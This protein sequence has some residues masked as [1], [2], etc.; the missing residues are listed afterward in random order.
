MSR[1]N[2]LPVLSAENPGVTLNHVRSLTSSVTTS[3]GVNWN[4]EFIARDI[5]QNFFDANR[6]QLDEV[7]VDVEGSK[8]TI[9][10]PADFELER[11]FYLGSEKGEG[12]I[13]QYGEG[14]KVAAV[15]LL[16]DHQIE[17]MVI[18]GDKVVYLRVET[19]KVSGT[20]LQPV[21][22][23]FFR[24]SKPAKGTRLILPG[25]SKNLIRALQ[26]GLTHFMY[27]ENPLLGAKLWSSWD[28]DFALYRATT[29]IGHIFYRS[30]KR[31]ETPDIPVVLVIDRKYEQIE[32]KIRHDRDRNAFGDE[33]MKSFYRHFAQKGVKDHADGQSAIVV[34]AA[35]C[36]TRGHALLNEVA[37]CSHSHW[38]RA[39][40]DSVFGDRFYAHSTA[41]DAAQSLEYARLEKIW[42]HEA[43]T[44]LP[45]YFGRFGV[46]NARH[47]CEELERK[48]SE[49]AR[50]RHHRAPTAAESSAIKLLAQIIRDLAP[51]T[52]ALFDRKTTN[53]SV[54][55]TEVVLGELKEKRSYYSQDVFLASSLFVADFAH[56]LAVFLHEHTHVFGQDG[57]RG[58][59]DALTELLE[60]LVRHRRDLDAFEAR[61]NE[62]QASIKLERQAGS[63]SAAEETLENVLEAMCQ[64]QL[65]DLLKRLP[66]IAVRGAL[67]SVEKQS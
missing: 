15:C 8:V 64:D 4:E 19:E 16:R 7:K 62:I 30:L 41:H 26:T 58:F 36:W 11:L 42:R 29:K 46:I 38:P 22:Y 48:A 14:L 40:L 1:K 37:D 65:K 57:S 60:T 44:P 33:L 9:S 53:Y 56:C 39:T 24:R 50:R 2:N 12:D 6:H 21:V 32:K 49:E 43:R 20:E 63:Q 54:A 59:S 66:A 55:E 61:W 51:T 28:H 10:A 25:C 27:P 47:H 31:G 52:M 23:D 13:G 67:Q 5:L 3:W 35:P 18:S 45:R 17:P 34:A